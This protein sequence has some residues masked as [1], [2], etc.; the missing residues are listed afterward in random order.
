M[1]SARETSCLLK[2]PRNSLPLRNI[3][4]WVKQ[5]FSHEDERVELIDGEIIE[6]SPTG[7]RHAVCVSRATTMFIEAFGRRVVV[8]PQNPLQLSDWTEPQPD[9]VVFKPR[10]DFY[11][12]KKPTPDDVLFTVEVSDTSLRFDRNVKLPRY[13]A[14]GIPE[15]W[16]EDLQNN[17]LLVYRDPTGKEYRTAFNLRPSDTV[18]PIAFPD[19]NFRI[20]D[21]LG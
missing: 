20:E 1:L 3:T 18:E 15:V 14:A 2:S 13:A 5:V 16:I 9:L 4:A 11:S 19:V 6:M 10:A 21:L 8:G 12:A 7:H 17:L